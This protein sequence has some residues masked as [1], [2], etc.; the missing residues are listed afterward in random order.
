MAEKFEV[1]KNHDKPSSKFETFLALKFSALYLYKYN[2]PSVSATIILQPI[3]Q[4]IP[5]P[6]VTQT[7]CKHQS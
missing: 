2:W 6:T 1:Q 3:Q 7:L 5:K 4:R